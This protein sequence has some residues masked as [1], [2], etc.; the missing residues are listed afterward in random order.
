VAEAT[1]F[2]ANTLSGT[3]KVIRGIEFTIV[4]SDVDT[5]IQTQLIITGNQSGATRSIPI[6]VNPSTD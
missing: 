6:T 2:F 3:A 1:P 4:P 5:V